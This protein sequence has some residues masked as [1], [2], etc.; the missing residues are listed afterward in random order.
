MIE[1]CF[2]CQTE[3]ETDI[4]LGID[5][6]E[7]VC[8]CPSCGKYTISLRHLGYLDKYIQKG[9]L[10]DEDMNNVA[11]YLC[12][13]KIDGEI[14]IKRQSPKS[15]ISYSCTITYGK[16]WDILKKGV[17][18]Q[19]SMQ[20]L[21]KLLLNIYKPGN[22]FAIEFDSDDLFPAMGYVRTQ[23]ELSKMIE[24]LCEL[25]FVK[26]MNYAGGKSFA[27]TIKGLER[28]E[29]LLTEQNFSKRAFIAMRFSDDLKEV[30]DKSIKPACEACG[31]E[32]YTV[33]EEEHVGDI[34]DKIISGIKTSRFVIADFTYNNPGVYYEA[35]YAKGLGI[36]VIKTC[37]KEWFESKDE[38]G[39]KNRL[40]FDVEHDNMILWENAEDLRQ[41]LESR[42]QAVI[43]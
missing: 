38:K 5:E 28:A 27:I 31:F 32:A 1:K 14:N 29:T 19:T 22:G 36:P 40:H 35:G 41:R 10:K 17:F 43:L 20:K 12:E 6:K 26:D 16:F 34:T 24:A 23:S 39:E 8:F 37:K 3:I 7:K 2:F 9:T 30:R 15:R 21:D 25:G 42:I 4:V 33:D 18:P 13:E 11:G